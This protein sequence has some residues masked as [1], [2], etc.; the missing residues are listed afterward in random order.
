MI[1]DKYPVKPTIETTDNFFVVTLPNV[2]VGTQDEN[3]FDDTN[4]TL[5]DTNGTISGTLNGTI[6]QI[7]ELIKKQSDI[8]IDELIETSHK[9]RRTVARAINELKE[10]GYIER[11]GSKKTG[12]WKV[13]K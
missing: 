2:K 8:T 1:Y 5:S 10:Q 4:D 12:F 6:K 11:V 9:A 13:L 7:Y 3:Y